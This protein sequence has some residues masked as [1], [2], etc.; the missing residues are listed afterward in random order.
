V[1][2]ALLCAVACALLGPG[3]AAAGSYTTTYSTGV[4][5][6]D[7]WLSYGLALVAPD[8]TRIPLVTQ[9]ADDTYGS[10]SSCAGTMVFDDSASA[11][12]SGG[13]SP[14]TGSFRPQSPLSALDGKQIK[15]TWGLRVFGT[16]T[17]YCFE[18][19]ITRAVNIVADNDPGKAGAAVRYS[20]P[21]G[22]SQCLPASGGF[23]RLGKTQVT[24]R[25]LGLPVLAFTVTVK[26]VEPPTIT[27]SDR[28][29]KN[30]P[31]Q[32][33]AVVDY[34][35]PAV[36]DNAPGVGSPSCSP[37]SG[38]T[39]PLGPTTVTC[40]ATDA[41]GNTATA[42]FTVTV[43]DTEPP[44]LTT[45]SDLSRDNDPDRAGAV[46]RYSPVVKDNAPNPTVTCTPR[47]GSFFPLGTTTVAC[48][49]VD[50]AGNTTNKT[51]R[52]KVVDTQPPRL[53]V[54][55]DFTVPAD[56]GKAGAVV[57][58]PPPVVADN[59]PG[60]AAPTCT[61]PSHSL[62]RI[63]RTTVTC[64][65]KDAAGNAAQ[66]AFAV[67][68]KTGSTGAKCLVPNLKGATLS[69]AAA[70]LR[71]ARCALGAVRRIYSATG[72]RGRVISQLVAAGR[73]LPKGTKV[74]LLVSRGPRP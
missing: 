69:A 50:G 20:T 40:K 1:K 14:F 45:P 64:T 59:A 54:P 6:L 57:A 67:T 10:A 18:L 17:V 43:N 74:S 58:Y 8:G 26:D 46:V 34:P 22:L 35:A 73:R 13:S 9:S 65:V 32:A 15:G 31:G 30:D 7:V 66:K 24:C 25:K 49:A 52:V 60:L 68:V 61:P 72:R 23:F 55:A 48:K 70:A 51:F 3:T 4:T 38:S 53:S 47:S 37:A 71:R 62:F 16:D 42:K 39:F 28:A 56:P 5:S 11:S 44:R 2:L 33:G 36:A 27:V 41:A 12:I 21:T 63:G 19:E 29:A